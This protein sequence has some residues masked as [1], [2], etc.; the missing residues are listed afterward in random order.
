MNRQSHLFIDSLGQL[1]LLAA[2]FYLLISTEMQYFRGHWQFYTL[3]SLLWQGIQAVISSQVYEQALR[4][5]FLRILGWTLLWIILPLSLLYFLFMALL[6]AS[7]FG[8][9]WFLSL[10][11][12]VF[13]FI[14]YALPVVFTFFVC[15]YYYLTA[16]DIYIVFKKTI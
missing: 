13:F 6:A 3:F 14:A 2:F 7:L 5:P 15:W 4:R 12:F 10:L 8:A 9:L 1:L 16:K 11:N